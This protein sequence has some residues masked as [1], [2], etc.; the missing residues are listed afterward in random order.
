MHR[1]YKVDQS[2]FKPG[3]NVEP[4]SQIQCLCRQY[5]YTQGT[6]L[7][8]FAPYHIG[9]LLDIIGQYRNHIRRVFLPDV[10]ATARKGKIQLQPIGGIFGGQFLQH[11]ELMVADLFVAQRPAAVFQTMRR[12]LSAVVGH[13]QA[14]DKIHVFFMRTVDQHLQGIKATVDQALHILPG[15]PVSGH[16]KGL[17]IGAEAHPNSGWVEQAIPPFDTIAEGIHCRTGDFIN[18]RPGVL[19]RHGGFE[20]EEVIVSGV[21]HIYDSVFTHDER[22]PR[23]KH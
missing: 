13:S 17:H 5:A 18:R 16:S 9:N 22:T 4:L 11:S 15:A 6:G 19:H 1:D 14:G 7:P 20:D 2:P 23:R 12:V 21:I 3:A 8:T 10:M